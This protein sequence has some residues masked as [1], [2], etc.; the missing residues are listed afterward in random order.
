LK[1][2][3]IGSGRLGL[4][5]ALLCESVGYE[6]NIYDI[7]KDY[8]EKLKNR[9]FSTTE[10]EVH[11]LLKHSKNLNIF[12]EFE[13]VVLA[14]DL[15]YT[16]VPT[17]SNL[18]GSYN[19]DIVNEIANNFKKLESK[20]TNK[21]YFIIGSTVNPGDS[22]KIG[23]LFDSS[24]VDVIY[25]PE[26]IAQGSIIKDLRS[27]DLV[28]VG[29]NKENK[30]VLSYIKEIYK[31]IQDIEINYQVM[32]TTAAEIT[33]ISINC[34]LTTKISFANVIGEILQNSKCEN[35]IDNVLDTIGKDKRIGSKY[36]KY[37]FGYGGPCLPRDN[38]ALASYA[39]NL[40]IK[41]NLGET[42]DKINNQ[43]GDFLLN[44]YIDN[45]MNRNP[46]YFD[47]ISYKKNTNIFE[48]SQQLKLCKNLL[49][50]DYK[51]YVKE[52]KFIT[53]EIREELHNDYQEN[54][55]FIK[56]IHKLNIQYIEVN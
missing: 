25:N 1:V 3:I 6:V 29:I 50:R 53:N 16:F 55:E 44:S 22:A 21:K 42:V 46:Y 47:F 13:E 48:E 14:S 49:E 41:H 40:G 38:R 31:N 18:D 37:G 7:D 11:N 27:A 36:L 51:V 34:F 15:V 5:F 9:K 20:I 39:S 24:K 30:K 2:G 54:I 10:P 4:C 8:L 45:N 33:K 43:H 32:S 23:N 12:N 56:D 52:S 17:P 26:F 28:L 19:I 35:E